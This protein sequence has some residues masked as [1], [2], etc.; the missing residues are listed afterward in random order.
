[1]HPVENGIPQGSPVL[2]I[3]A[4]FYSV[5][6][7]ECFAPTQQASTFPH[8]NQ[9]TE[10]NL[11]MY[12]NN[13]KLYTSSKSLDTNVT[14]LKAA[15]T[16]TKAWL[17]S[18]G[19]SSDVAKREIMHYSRRRGDNSSPSITLQDIDGIMRTVTPTATVRW[20][21]IYFDRK[22]HFEHHT[23]LLAARGKNAVDEPSGYLAV[24]FSNLTSFEQSRVDVIR[25]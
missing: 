2:P 18:A 4:A 20:L 10:T 16:K 24:Y 17:Q 9:A 1:M 12:I 15:Y 11:L 5:E 25:L 13:S 23:K 19:L 6:L 22:L 7:L 8:P 14:T 3:L 21:G